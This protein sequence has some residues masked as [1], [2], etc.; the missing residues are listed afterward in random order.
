MIENW[1]QLSAFDQGLVIM[2]AAVCLV[3]IL[4]ALAYDHQRSKIDDLRRR[5]EYLEW[6][7]KNKL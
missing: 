3:I 7:I 5:I 2:L 4:G 1:Q 6:R